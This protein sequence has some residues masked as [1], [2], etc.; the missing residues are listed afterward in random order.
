M[1]LVCFKNYKFYYNPQYSNYFINED[2]L[3]FFA[4]EYEVRIHISIHKGKI[5][6]RPRYGVTLQ[7][8]NSKVYTVI[9][10]I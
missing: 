9:A 6:F 5:L 3:T 1:K 7:R 10:N 4:S 2:S 8:I